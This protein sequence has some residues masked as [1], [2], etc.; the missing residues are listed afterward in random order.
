M[1]ENAWQQ[2][3]A[4]SEQSFLDKSSMAFLHLAPQYVSFGCEIG[5]QHGDHAVVHVSKHLLTKWRRQ[6]LNEAG[7]VKWR[8]VSL[9][10]LIGSH[11][12]LFGSLLC[13]HLWKRNITDQKRI[14]LQIPLDRLSSHRRHQSVARW[15]EVELGGQLFTW[16]W[17]HYP[18]TRIDLLWW[19]W[20]KINYLWTNQDQCVSCHKKWVLQRVTSVN[21]ANVK[22]CYTSS[23]AAHRPS[24]RVAYHS[25]TWLKMPLFNGWCHTA[26]NAHDNNNNWNTQTNL[27]LPNTKS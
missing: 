6:R 22:Q 24:R 12:R 17:L 20:S 25:F 18:A 23:T 4:L 19:Y 1:S 3:S 13:Q 5:W 10:I 14:V 11:S 2:T 27:Q 16:R 21:V 15:L 8:I 7:R 26:H 9:T